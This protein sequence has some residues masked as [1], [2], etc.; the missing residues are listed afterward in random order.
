MIE[1]ELYEDLTDRPRKRR[2]VARLIIA[3]EVVALGV[4]A[5]LWTVPSS[6]GK[7][8]QPDPSPSVL[9]STVPT[10][11]APSTTRPAT[12]TTTNV[13]ASTTSGPTSTIAVAV[14]GPETTVPPVSPSVVAPAATAPSRRT[15]TTTTTRPPRSST[16]PTGTEPAPAA[17][18]EPDAT[19]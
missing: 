13:A 6:G 5:L 4:L 16:R 19:T 7:Q 14:V 18:P 17:E 11:V 2:R 1:E 10:T 15:T 9:V 12:S 3:G 8:T